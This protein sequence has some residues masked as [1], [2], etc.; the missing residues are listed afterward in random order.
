[1][2]NRLSDELC[3]GE[4]FVLVNGQIFFEEMFK[5]PKFVE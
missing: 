4:Y 1:M 5:K 3:T 2:K